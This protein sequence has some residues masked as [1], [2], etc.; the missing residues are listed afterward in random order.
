LIVARAPVRPVIWPIAGDWAD[1]PTTEASQ[2]SGTSQDN[3]KPEPSTVIARDTPPLPTDVTL[4]GPTLNFDG[5]RIDTVPST[6]T[7]QVPSAQAVSVVPSAGT[8]N[9]LGAAGTDEVVG[10]LVGGMVV[11][12]PGESTVGPD[13]CGVDE[14]PA[15]PSSAIPMR[16]FPALWTARHTSDVMGD[17][18]P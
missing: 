14:H 12:V 3:E 6:R 13:P 8:G 2:V 9:V 1:E 16:T 4:T 5:T 17:I 10:E 11:D 7:S 18:P 15:A